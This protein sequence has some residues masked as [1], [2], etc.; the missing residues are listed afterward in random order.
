[1]GGSNN[2]YISKCKNDKIKINNK[3]ISFEMLISLFFSLSCEVCC[4][5]YPLLSY[6]NHKFDH[7]NYID[8]LPHCSA[9]QKTSELSCFFWP[10]SPRLK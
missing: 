3:R 8:L 10:A 6:N 2:V 5:S 1:M 9:G 7:F 4:I